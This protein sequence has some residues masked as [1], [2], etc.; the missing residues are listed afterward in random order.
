MTRAV[1][2]RLPVFSSDN[3]KS[4]TCAESYSKDLKSKMGGGICNRSRSHG[5]RGEGRSAAAERKSLG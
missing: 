2:I 4:K 3:R 5:V 1:S